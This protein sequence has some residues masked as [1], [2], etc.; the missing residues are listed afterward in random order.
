ML[1][2]DAKYNK[3]LNEKEKEDIIEI[4]C[5]DCHEDFEIK[6]NEATDGDPMYCPF[7]GA[8]IE[9]DQEDED[10]EIDDDNYGGTE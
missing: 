8:D 4:Q 9:Y 6:Y 1:Q 2:E 10:D 7:C 5:Q 3:M